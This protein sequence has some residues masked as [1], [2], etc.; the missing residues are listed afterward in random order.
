MKRLRSIDL[1]RGWAILVMLFANLAP[2]FFNFSK[3]SYIRLLFS[4]AAPIFIFLTGHVTEMKLS[5]N[6]SMKNKI[7]FRI[8]QVLFLGVLIDVFIWKI[9]PFVTFD[10]LYL[11]SFAQFLILILSF[12]KSMTLKWIVFFC[13]IIISLVLQKTYNYRIELPE[14]GLGIFFNEFN[15]I[16]ES[17]PIKRAFFDGWFP[18]FPWIAF[19]LIGAISYHYQK[20]LNRIYYILIF[21]GIF[22]L[23]VVV[24]SNQFNVN[25]VRN[26]YLELW[27][28]PFGFMILIPISMVSL[29]L[30]CI[31]KFNQFSNS[32]FSTILM[33]LGRNSL[34]I[35]LFQSLLNSI[36]SSNIHIVHNSQKLN[37]LIYFSIIIFIIIIANLIEKIKKH[38]WWEKFPFIIK[39]FLGY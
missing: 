31:A 34:F 2:T 25:F 12:N 15:L 35:Y 38:E 21:L 14:L 19:S 8:I 26:G 20:Y 3:Y 37:I 7:F 32:F 1:I 10:V 9:V 4:T 24:K 28:P 5:E 13:I 6:K 39:F 30:A 11:I 23:F 33:N 18:I 29:T 36:C 16:I 27:Y 17:L 22:L